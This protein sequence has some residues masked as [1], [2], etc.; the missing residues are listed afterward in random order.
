MARLRSPERKSEFRLEVGGYQ[1]LKPVGDDWDDN[2]LVLKMAV[3]TPERRWSGHG[4]YLTTFELTHLLDRLKAWAADGKEET[5][6]FSSENL[7][8][9][10]KSGGRDL[11]ALKVGFDLGCHPEA[12]GK[13]GNPLWVRF[14][15]TPA[16]LVEFVNELEKEAAP[17]PERHLTGTKKLFKKVLKKKV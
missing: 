7:A 6:T 13:A 4:P 12:P 11:V 16:E 17:Y 8:F 9:S 14:D 15:V 10:R 5:L 3:D 2:W 1:L